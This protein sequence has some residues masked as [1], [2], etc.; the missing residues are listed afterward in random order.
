MI[1]VYRVFNAVKDLA[2]KEQKGFVTPQVFNSFAQVA[3]LNIYNEM[4]EELQEAKKARLSQ[5]DVGGSRGKEKQLLEDLS[6][7][8]QTDVISPIEQA[9]GLFNKPL[10]LSKILA[11]ETGNIPVR[12]NLDNY[13]NYIK[14]FTPC[15]IVYDTEKANQILNSH[16]SAP[17]EDF[18]VALVDNYIEIFPTQASNQMKIRYYKMPGSYRST[19]NEETPMSPI[20]GYTLTGEDVNMYVY[21]PQTSL[22]FMMPPHYLSELVNEICILKR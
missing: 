18:P 7:F 10:R 1:S 17:T 3:Q 8:S 20:F 9:P 11:I 16:L 15:E 21:N 12:P 19:D 5:V 22:N 14:R 4:F 6:Y 13:G 2:N